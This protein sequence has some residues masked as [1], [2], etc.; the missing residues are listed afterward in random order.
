M[1]GTR[2]ERSV[3]RAS[4]VTVSLLALSSPS[5]VKALQARRAERQS[6]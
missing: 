5:I 2:M 3:N 6:R 1:S 4:G